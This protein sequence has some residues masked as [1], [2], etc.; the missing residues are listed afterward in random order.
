MSEP[1]NKHKSMGIGAL[2]NTNVVFRNKSRW[3]FNLQEK[4]SIPWTNPTTGV[5]HPCNPFEDKTVDHTAFFVKVKAVNNKELE[6]VPGVKIAEDADSNFNFKNEATKIF[7]NL[8]KEASETFWQFLKES[9]NF[10]KTPT[11]EERIKLALK[12]NGVFNLYDGCGG[13]METWTLHN[14][15]PWTINFSDMDYTCGQDTYLEVILLYST[16]TFKNHRPLPQTQECK[17][18]GPEIKL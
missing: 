7:F 11:F 3:Y 1:E 8:P 14:I 2:G 4:V 6:G 16:A 10:D 17:P 15:I 12:W 9:L 13:L 18:E 5:T